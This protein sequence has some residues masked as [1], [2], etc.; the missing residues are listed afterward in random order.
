[1]MNRIRSLEVERETAWRVHCELSAGVDEVVLQLFT[2]AQD[3]PSDET[4]A[5][6]L[7][8]EYDNKSEGAADALSRHMRASQ[9]IERLLTH[10]PLSGKPCV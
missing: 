5:R 1:M 10:Q 7:L 3:G 9:D 2:L 6:T 4:R 8:A